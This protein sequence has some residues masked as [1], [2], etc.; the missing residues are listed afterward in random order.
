MKI[1]SKD[2]LC[3]QP[4]LNIRQLLNRGS[5]SQWGFE[6][7]SHVLKVDEKAAKEIINELEDLGYISKTKSSRGKIYYE[8]TLKGNSLSLATAAKPISR[9]SA[10]VKLL[11]LTGRIKEVNRDSNYL[12]FVKKAYIFGSFLS[13]AEQL[14]DIDIA[15]EIL[16]KEM[17]KELQ[18]KLER[19]RTKEA[20]INGRTFNT[21]MDEL[22]WPYREVLL[23]LKSKSRSISLHTTDDAIL[24]QVKHELFFEDN[25]FY[26]D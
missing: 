5:A 26:N 20:M 16:P 13:T 22:F 8:N 7:V 15:L 6:F 23:Y 3:G 18:Q 19:E 11:E 10:E 17:D 25:S 2:I 14:G 12:F 24:K 4:I 1:N 9:K 21:F